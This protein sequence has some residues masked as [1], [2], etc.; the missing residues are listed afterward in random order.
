MDYFT[1]LLAMFLDVDPVNYITVYG[2]D[3]EQSEC[4][5]NILICVLKTNETFTGLKGHLGVVNDKIFILGWSNPLM[6]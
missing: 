1:D 6:G 3:R 2:R 4:I 5:K